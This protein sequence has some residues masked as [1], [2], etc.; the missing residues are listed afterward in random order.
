MLP[1]VCLLELHARLA[2]A[3]EGIGHELPEEHGHDDAAVRRYP[4]EDLVGDIA[5]MRVHG[6]RAGV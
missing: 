6:I 2:V 4:A 3:A 5:R 1:L